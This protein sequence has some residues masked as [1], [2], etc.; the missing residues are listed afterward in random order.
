M[1]ILYISYDGATDNLGQSQ[2]IPYIRGLSEEG[3]NFTLITFEKEAALRNGALMDSVR[4]RLS[5]RIDWM[6][7]KYHKTP[8]VIVTAY[9]IIHGFLFGLRE[10]KKKNIKIVH[11]RSFIGSVIAL[12]LKKALRVKVL[13][14]IRGFWPE[15]RVEGGLWRENGILFRIA[16]RVERSLIMNADEIVVLTQNAKKEIG[17]LDYLKNKGTGINVIPTCVDINNGVIKKTGGVPFISRELDN[18]FVISYIGSV[19]T[20]YMP[21]EIFRFFDAARGVINNAFLLILTKEKKFLENLLKRNGQRRDDISVLSVEQGLVPQYLSFAKAG[22]AFYKPGYSRKACSPTKFGEYLACGLPVIINKGIGDCDEIV[23]KENI[24][25]VING[26]SEDEYKRAA[27]ELLRLLSEGERLKDRC[28]SA[29]KRYFSLDM[30]VERYRDIYK[31][32]DKW[33]M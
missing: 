7:L 5:G 30:G 2:I 18:K 28:R 25:V 29:A 14:D 15:E 8:S 17:G 13:L 23:L 33:Q 26:F 10:I 31:R 32:L 9:D 1:E 19:S 11:G 22:L 24:G 21:A 3:V 20:W 12:F 16:K 4:G 6:P 27:A